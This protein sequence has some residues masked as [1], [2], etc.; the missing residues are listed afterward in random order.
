MT[1]Y[2]ITGWTLSIRKLGRYTQRSE[3]GYIQKTVMGMVCYLFGMAIFQ[4]AVTELL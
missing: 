2:L 1:N 3:K 4:D